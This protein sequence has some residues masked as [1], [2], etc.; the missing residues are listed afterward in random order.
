MTVKCLIVDDEFP[1]RRLLEQYLTDFPEVKLVGLCAN[2]D[3]CKQVLQKGPVD[4]LFLDIQMPGITGI[5]LLRSLRHRP[6]VILTTAYPN[7]ALEGFE[8]QVCDYLLKPIS[9]D[10][11]KQAMEKALKS[12]GQRQTDNEASIAPYIMI[13]A[14]HKLTR[15]MLHDIRYIEGLREYVSIYTPN[16]RHIVLEALKNL[17]ATLPSDK[18]AR[19]HRSYIVAKNRV[20]S[21]S[22]SFLELEG[23]KIPIGKSYRDSVHEWFK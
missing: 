21:I 4:I 22:G 6:E 12:L 13:K 11:F 16:K 23:K 20:E 7:Y 9:P 14:D 19:V 1:A 2:A 15:V 8:L 10:R 5:E 18:F 3:E 17:E